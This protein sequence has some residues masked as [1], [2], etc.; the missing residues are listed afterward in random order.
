MIFTLLPLALVAIALLVWAWIVTLRGVRSAP[1]PGWRRILALI[2][3][4]AATLLVPLPY[5]MLLGFSDP[6][7][8]AAIAWSMKAA[9]LLFALSLPGAFLLKGWLLRIGL[10]LSSTF[11]LL[12]CGAIYAISGWQF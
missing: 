3:L 9:V 8:L 5:I 11:F 12:F 6:T 2:G 7:N 1:A 10:V 4:L